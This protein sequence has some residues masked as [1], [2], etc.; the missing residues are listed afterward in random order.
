MKTLRKIKIINWH[1]FWNETINIEPIVF[2]TGLNA[3]GKSTL[4]DAM[5]IVLL[6][7]T[8]GRFFNKAASEKSSR[9][10]KGYLRGELGDSEDGGFK[11]LR[12]GRFTSYIALEFYD[13]L[14][15]KSFT[16]GCV[17]DSYDDG[18]EEHRYF[19]L[20]NKIPENEFIKDKI[21]MDYKTLAQFFAANY[22]EGNYRFVDTNKQYQELLK[23]KFGNIKDKYF[24][25]FKKAVSFT[26]ITD[27]TTF[28]TEYICDAQGNINI[29]SMQENIL[30]YKRLENEA[31]IMGM[32]VDRLV[33]IETSYKAYQSNY[34]NMSIYGYIVEKAE[35]QIEL[36][37]LKSYDD[38]IEK[39]QKRLIEIETELA[40]ID[41]NIAEL[42]RRKTRLI[43][44]KASS[45]TYRL[46]DELREQRQEALEKLAS[47]NRDAQLVRQNLEK[48][49]NDFIAVA[50]H[51]VEKLSNLDQTLLNDDRGYEFNEL[52]ECAAKV[53]ETSTNLRDNELPHI[54][55][56]SIETLKEWRDSL[57]KF[58]QLVSA[59]SVS[60]GRTITTF[61]RETAQL[62]QQEAEMRNGSKSYDRSLIT[63]KNELQ[64]I[65]TERHGKPVVVSL[66]A[67][68]I[69]IKSQ[70]WVNAIEGFL[71]AQKFNLFVENKYYFEAYEILRDLLAKNHFY[72]TT[73]VDQEKIIERN[74]TCEKGSLAEEIITDH[75]GARSYTNFLIG[76]LKKC[77]NVQEA[78]ESMNGI[79]PECD[80]YRNFTLG[81]LNPRL[82][83]PAYIGRSVGEAQIALKHAE[84][85]RNNHLVA[86]LRNIHK[87]IAEANTFEIIN[88]NE[89]NNTIT[90]IENTRN[91]EGL[92][93]TISYLDEEL[94]KHDVSQIESF[95]RRIKDVE[96]DIKNLEN[97]KQALFE[98]RGQ[99][100]T[101]I[102]TLKE[103]KIPETKLKS[104]E[105]TKHLEENYD[106][107][108]VAEESEPLF[109]QMLVEGKS[110][111]EMVSE[112]N[113]KFTQA[114]Y[115]AQ[116]IFNNV[117]KLRREYVKD[118]RLSYD[119]DQKDNDAYEKELIDLREIKL[120]QYQLAITDAYNKATKQFKD[121]FISRLRSAIESVEI[122]IEDLNEALSH[123]VFGNDTYRFTCRPSQLYHRYYEMI[124][125]D[126]L[127]QVGED[128][129]AFI[130]KYSEVM[131]DLFRQ[132][133]DVGEHGDKNAQLAANVEKFTDYRSYLDFDL[134]VKNKEGQEQRLSKMMKKKS[135]G[136]T[137]TPFYIAVLA[138]FAQLYRVNDAGELGNS[139]R[140]IV[141][142]EAFS[143]MDRGRITESVRLLRKF[144]LQ[145]ILSAPSDKIADISELVD[146]TLV[147]L[148]DKN[149]SRV[150]LYAEEEKITNK[151]AIGQ[152]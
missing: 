123:A 24:S 137:Q 90:L 52:L 59:M 82:Y 35:L 15:D 27:I 3:S 20:E 78:R 84:I 132:I 81:K 60:L 63:I 67:D 117:M 94:S 68:L 10:L 86:I 19:C 89:I 37:R 8:S 2:L 55:T 149:T 103:E 106:P 18:S 48:Y 144:G 140:L 116:T 74:Y 62:K 110:P 151:K 29:D 109:N 1:Y 77:R 57:A 30:Q 118:Y 147:V 44:D 133:V 107:F 31:T 108:V 125:D 42:N 5:Q 141:F 26:P 127:L 124:K 138:S 131:N 99:L 143:K 152:H 98:E 105:R 139:I 39:A 34:H 83:N 33:E 23:K 32:R 25:L 45:D 41:V 7:D 73:L 65:L 112:Y 54:E 88:T 120:P 36:N 91:V 64:R 122:Q 16:L 17:F 92:K 95:D 71:H 150:R 145:A 9:T 96:E 126:L 61:D 53:V 76:R 134:I 115:K 87:D 14:N 4:I 136:E 11:Y 148:H 40:D 69:D 111:I 13:D 128:E 97:E 80:L 129:S 72:G 130:E 113:V 6:G 56:L 114:Q 43:Q 12:E 50:S 38:S 51:I 47:L 28:I 104:E 22:G 46:T 85:D 121:D 119:T 142:D 102:K 79:T 101:Q 49:A 93:N 135:G 66:F 21:P 75:E 146:E 100:N 70:T 58:K